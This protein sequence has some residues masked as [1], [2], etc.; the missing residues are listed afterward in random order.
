MKKNPKI[1]TFLLEIP[2]DTWNKWKDT[3]PRSISLNNALI[4]LLQKEGGKDE[5]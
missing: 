3:V 5:K 2:E 1:K 4:E